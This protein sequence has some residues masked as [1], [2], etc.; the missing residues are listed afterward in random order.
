MT[1]I[2]PTT[3]TTNEQKP[4][5]RRVLQYV[6]VLGW[7][8]NWE[9]LD[10]ANAWAGVALLV[11]AWG[12]AILL[13]GYAGLILPALFMVFMMFAAIVLISRG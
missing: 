1:T 2:D 5:W 9:D 12:C 4:L 10:A 8:L 11:S 6:P 3:M 13:F 7:M